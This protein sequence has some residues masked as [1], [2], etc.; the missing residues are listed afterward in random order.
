[1]PTPSGQRPSRVL[2]AH[3]STDLY[4]ADRM[5]LRS[6]AALADAGCEVTVALPAQ[7]QL[8]AEARGL[9]LHVVQCPMAVLRKGAL[10]PVRLLRLMAVAL[11]SMR[12]QVALARAADVV[13]VN[14]VTIP[15]WVLVARL[16][17][18]RVVVHAREAEVDASAVLR[19]GLL[20]PLLLA[21]L[22]VCNST[23]TESF[24][25]GWSLGSGIRT[26]VV[27]N[28]F[29]LPA[30]E[31]PP[32]ASDTARLALVGRLWRWPATPLRAMSGTPTSCVARRR[33]WT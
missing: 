26:R 15:T 29:T 1:M 17:R 25:R 11:A 8:W 5:M 24:V 10:T 14:T 4:G 28:G 7:G 18:R 32:P 3:P 22:A 23:A 16:L 2:V 13:Y 12:R 20:A 6:A 31:P 9:G 30:A 19:A 27:H 33:G 21:H